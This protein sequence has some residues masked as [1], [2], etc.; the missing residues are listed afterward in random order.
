MAILRSSHNQIELPSNSRIKEYA[1]ELGVPFG[2]TQGLCGTCQI[3]I[4]EGQENL[5]PL[6]LE[7]QDMQRDQNN[8]LACQCII[9][10]GSVTIK[11]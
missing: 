1:E 8:R 9:K 3:E 2:C 5:A 10:N 11:W 4:I 6:T 7:E